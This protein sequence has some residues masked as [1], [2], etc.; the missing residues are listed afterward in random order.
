MITAKQMTIY[1]GALAYYDSMQGL[2][3]CKVLTI[4]GPQGYQGTAS[5]RICI[6]VQLTADRGTWRKREVIRCVSSLWVLPRGCVL[7]RKQGV[8]IL[9]N[10]HIINIPSYQDKFRTPRCHTYRLSTT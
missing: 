8:R 1:V 10:H 5:H 6:D 2:L 3:P 9:K 4:H 7:W